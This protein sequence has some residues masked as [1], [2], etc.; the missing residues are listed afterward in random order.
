MCLGFYNMHIK[1]NRKNHL[2]LHILQL[3]T[4]KP[5]KG[6]TTEL[7]IWLWLSVCSNQPRW[8]HQFRERSCHHRAYG[9]RGTKL[10]GHRRTSVGCYFRDVHPTNNQMD[11]LVEKN[12][13]N[14]LE[15]NFFS[16]LVMQRTRSNPASS[17]PSA[18]PLSSIITYCYIAVD[19]N[20]ILRWFVSYLMSATANPT[21]DVVI[22]LLTH[23]FVPFTTLLSSFCA[24]I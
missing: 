20:H 7:P 5:I 14:I 3:K 4:Q 19:N 2:L 18:G 11:L 15:S 21:Y 6:L 1:T 24:R 17:R 23:Y 16:L 13:K 12:L 9:W 22:N 10:W 8:D